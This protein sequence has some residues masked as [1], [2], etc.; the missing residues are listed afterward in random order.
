MSILDAPN[1][2]VAHSTLPQRISRTS[3]L[4][5]EY[6]GVRMFRFVK[7]TWI[8]VRFSKSRQVTDVDPV[9]FDITLILKNNL[10][11]L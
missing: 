11:L 3:S 9:Y 1:P 7:K 6:C 4:E 5:T 2:W 10:A 8:L